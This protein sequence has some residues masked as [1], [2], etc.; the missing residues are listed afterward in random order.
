MELSDL[1]TNKHEFSDFCR[2]N[3]SRRVGY[4]KTYTSVF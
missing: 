4:N 2:A 1:Q 3:E